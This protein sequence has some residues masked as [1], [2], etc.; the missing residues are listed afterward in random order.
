MKAAC[1]VLWGDAPA[2]AAEA[3]MHVRW[4]RRCLH[5][6][7]D[8]LKGCFRGDYGG[9]DVS[10]PTK[11]PDLSGAIVGVGHVQPALSAHDIPLLKRSLRASEPLVGAGGRLAGAEREKAKDTGGAVGA[12]GLVHKAIVVALAAGFVQAILG[13]VDGF[14]RVHDAAPLLCQDQHTPDGQKPRTI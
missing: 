11:Q 13:E 7:R 2:V 1:F 5:S 10:C 4:R 14:V 6:P 8:H 3:V 12:F 9:Q